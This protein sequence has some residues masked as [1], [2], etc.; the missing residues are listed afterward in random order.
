VLVA[1]LL[2]GILMQLSGYKA[3]C[4]STTDLRRAMNQSPL[5]YKRYVTGYEYEHCR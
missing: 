5:V 3:S 2:I 4:P 1:P